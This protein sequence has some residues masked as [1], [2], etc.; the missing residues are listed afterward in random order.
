MAIVLLSLVC[1]FLNIIIHG[2][3]LIGV[4]TSFLFALSLFFFENFSQQKLSSIKFPYLIFLAIM[5][6]FIHYYDKPILIIFSIDIISLFLIYL[7]TKFYYLLPLIFLSIFIGSM[8]ATEIIK[9]PFLFHPDSLIFNDHWTNEAIAGMPKGALYLPH[10]IRPLVFNSSVYF[11]VLISKTAELFMIK[12]LYDVLL[13]A[14][15]YP[16]IKG[17]ILDFRSW[18]R[19]KTIISLCIFTVAFT[20]VSSRAVDIFNTFL[21]M[22]PF[23]TY[24]ILRGLGFINRKIYILFLIFSLF[25]VTSPF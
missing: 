8:Y 22:S 16:L 24:F 10:S 13:F 21:L 5:P 12:N 7:K 4:L 25:I 9:P 18:N 14:N 11:Y 20:T 1:F 19:Q 15:L 2:H 6:V 3:I 23:L 17:V